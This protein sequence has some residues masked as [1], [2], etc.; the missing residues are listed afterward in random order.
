MVCLRCEGWQELA[1]SA[2]KIGKPRLF[3]TGKLRRASEFLLAA[4][5]I[6]QKI[7]ENG[8]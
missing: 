7:R 2:K 8:P 4:V 5:R 3:L 1:C 6:W